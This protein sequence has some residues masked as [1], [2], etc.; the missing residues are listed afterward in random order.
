MLPCCSKQVVLSI[1]AFLCAFAVATAQDDSTTTHNYNRWCSWHRSPAM[2]I[3]YGSVQQTLNG[4]TQ[5]MASLRAFHL[6]LGGAKISLLDQAANVLEYRYHYGYVATAS[7]DLGG[8]VGNGEFA[9]ELWKFGGGWDKGYGYAFGDPEGSTGILLTHAQSMAL[10]TVRPRTAFASPADSALFAVFE[11]ALRFGTSM[12]AGLKIRLTPLVMIESG[13]ERTAVFRRF[14]V[15]EWLGS[16]CI[17]GVGHWVIDRFVSQVEHS[18]PVAVPLV[19]FVLKNAYSYAVYQLRRYM[20]NF[21]FDS[22]GSMTFDSFR[23]GVTL[24]F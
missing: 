21:P 24:V 15:W 3:D 4:F 13:F 18:S 16:A 8:T 20:M 14:Q 12:E 22:E 11:G 7:P 19:H 2:S 23:V 6:K 5:P 10:S 1:L 9:A 17:E